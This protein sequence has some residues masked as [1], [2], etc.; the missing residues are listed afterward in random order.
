VPIV[1]VGASDPLLIPRSAKY[2]PDPPRVHPLARPRGLSLSLS[3]SPLF[4]SLPLSASLRR[5]Q[6]LLRPRS[7]PAVSSCPTNPLSAPIPSATLC[8]SRAL[9]RLCAIYRPFAAMSHAS[10]R[11]NKRASERANTSFILVAAANRLTNQP[12]NQ[13]RRK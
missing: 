10:E 9:T 6:A 2:R 3:L 1:S 11:A 12:T 8:V 7:H 5:C 4:L 13:P